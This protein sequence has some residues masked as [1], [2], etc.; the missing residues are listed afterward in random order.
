MSIDSRRAKGLAKIL[1]AD[2]EPV[3]ADLLTSVLTKAG[4]NVMVVGDGDAALSAARRKRPELI[5]LDLNLPDMDGLLVC[6]SLREEADIPVLMLTARDKLVDKVLGF[7]VGADDYIT[8]PFSVLELLARVKAL[9]RRTERAALGTAEMVPRVLRSGELE[10]DLLRHE[11]RL[12]GRILNLKPME[13]DLLTFLMSH[14]GQA[15][16]K[17]QLLSEVWGYD[18]PWET[19]TVVVHVGWLRRKIEADPANPQFIET[20]GGVGYR[21]KRPDDSGSAQPSAG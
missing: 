10:V 9:L 1:V 18:S 2:D 8:K 12:S 17:D 5:I 20:V 15:F 11:A 19:R 16:T 14:P 3:V 4:Y 13:F 21:F 7:D 6:R